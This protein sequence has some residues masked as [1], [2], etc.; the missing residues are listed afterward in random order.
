MPAYAQA[1]TSLWAELLYGGV[2]APGDLPV[3]RV[4]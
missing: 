4:N 1:A 2:I 3:P